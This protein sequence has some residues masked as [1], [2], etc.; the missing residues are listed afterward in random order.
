MES[1]F[2]SFRD[3]LLS[4]TPDMFKK[5]KQNKLGTF[6]SKKI[7]VKS[8]KGK[9]IA[10]KSSRN[11]FARLLVLSRTRKIDLKELFHYRLSEYP[12]SLA[13]VSGSL[14]K[15]AKAKMLEILEPLAENP[16]VDLENLGEQNALVVDAMAVLQVMKGKWKTFG[17]FADST[18]TYLVGLA[19]Q[20]KA[21]RLDFVAD[22]YPEISIKSAER[23]RRASLQGK[24]EIYLFS[25]IT[26]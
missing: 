6:L 5:I 3:N 8:N 7:N 19:R 22:R 24:E 9:V 21:T 10:V 1:Q 15:T 23:E 20:Y 2:S 14:V 11:L 16:V 18:F 12:L 26:M 4:D 17:E 13:T 25:T